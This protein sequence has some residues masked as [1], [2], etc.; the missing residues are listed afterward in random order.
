MIDVDIKT[1]ELD[2]LV[3]GLKRNAAER[4]MKVEKALGDS[5]KI[6]ERFIQTHLRG[7][8][9]LHVQ[10]GALKS[11]IASEIRK[12]GKTY[13]GRVG[14]IGPGSG[15][16]RGPGFYGRVL[17]FGAQTPGNIIKP[18]PSNKRGL[19]AWRSKYGFVK[20]K[21]AGPLFGG[22]RLRRTK[23]KGHWIFA[24]QVHMPPKPWLAPSLEEARP[25][26]FRILK[27]ASVAITLRRGGSNR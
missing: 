11:S 25:H 20:S 13:H 21:K 5:L 15:V 23:N 1:K 19:L 18:K 8:N 17:E 16:A 3:I 4:S 2:A 14:A 12:M 10:S 24:K 6:T 26:I 27:K 9:P 22:Y 7:G